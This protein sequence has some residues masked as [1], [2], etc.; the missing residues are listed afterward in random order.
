MHLLQALPEADS[1]Q[2]SWLLLL[3]SLRGSAARIYTPAQLTWRRA[4]LVNNV[5]LAR[6]AASAGLDQQ[7][8]AKSKQ[9]VKAINRF[10][11]AAR[12]ATDDDS[13]ASND[14]QQDQGLGPGAS[15]SSPDQQ[16]DECLEGPAAA[17]TAVIDDCPA[18]EEGPGW[19]ADEAD[20]IWSEVWSSADAAS[21]Q[22]QAQQTGHSCPK[23]AEQLCAPKALAD[24]VESMIGAVFVDGASSSSTGGGNAGGA[25]GSRQ[26]E[27]DASG[28]WKVA[29][30]A[31]WQ[32]V[33]A[34]V[35]RQQ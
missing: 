5:N 13:T 1:C 2:L 20:T 9:L 30:A 25:T 31:V 28:C 26:L 32:L 23:H 21:G 7:L 17:A 4:A 16:G 8:T 27:A 18:K 33:L 12:T 6:V 15:M 10:A 19:I 11:A 24:V 14:G 3:T 29:W 34:G 22:G 35:K